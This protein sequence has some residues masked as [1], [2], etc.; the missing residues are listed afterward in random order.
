MGNRNSGLKN[1]ENPFNLDS[2]ESLYW[3][4]YLCADGTIIHSKKLGSYRTSIVSIDEDIIEKFRAFIGSR[5]LYHKRKQGNY[6][7]VYINSRQLTEYLISLGIT[8]KKSKTINPAIP[9]CAPFLR[10]VFDGDGHIRKTSRECKLVTSSEKFLERFTEY[11]DELGV[12][13]K[14]R[15]Y[16]SSYYVCI[17]RVKDTLLWLNHI[18]KD[19][20]IFMNRKYQR[21]VALSSDG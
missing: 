17:E 4:G 9:F 21:Y 6:S 15:I 13:F 10:G 1:F 18:Y 11:L 19:A 12:Y 7:E 14:V 3:L 16:G 8:Q 20:T 2:E 5:A